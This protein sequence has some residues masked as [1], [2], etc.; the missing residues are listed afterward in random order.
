VR[1]ITEATRYRIAI[2]ALGGVSR[3]TAGDCLQA[4]TAAVA[5]MGEIMRVRQPAAPVR[6]ILALIGGIRVLLT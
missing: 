3:A 5:M 6:E 4:G 2:V 1:A